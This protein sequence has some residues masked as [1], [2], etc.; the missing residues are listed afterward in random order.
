LGFSST[1]YVEE[2]LTPHLKPLYEAAGGL[3]KEVETIEDGAS[4]HTSAYKCRH[5]GI[6][7]LAWPAHSPDLNPIE[8]VWSL[9]KKNMQNGSLEN[10][11][12]PHTREELI[13]LAQEVWEGLPWKTIYKYID[14][15]PIR[16]ASCLRRSGGPTRF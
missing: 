10:E 7:K 12:Y 13:D 5:L 2:I 3:E 6:R 1:Q 15:M 14:S 9:F 16:V 4:Y 11:K 8:N